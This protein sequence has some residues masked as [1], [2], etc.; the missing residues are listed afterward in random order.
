MT[1]MSV[2]LCAMLSCHIVEAASGQPPAS[3]WF[4]GFS[5]LTPRSR[6]RTICG[7]EKVHA[8][9]A[10]RKQV[11]SEPHPLTPAPL[12]PRARESQSPR[13]SRVHTFATQPLPH[14]LARPCAIDTR[15]PNTNQLELPRSLSGRVLRPN[16]TA[17][18]QYSA[19]W[20]RLV[21]DRNVVPLNRL[22]ALGSRLTDFV[23]SSRI[24]D[25][26][27]GLAAQQSCP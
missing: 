14:P 5:T 2:I 18:Q 17:A 13:P 25:C 24:S 8:C 9:H 23:R 26:S 27:E 12:N 6:P 3:R 1:G 4:A 22:R 7:R 11:T 21:P 15:G 10:K 16:W 20:V 19:H